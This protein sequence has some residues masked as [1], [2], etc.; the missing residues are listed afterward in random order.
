MMARARLLYVY[1]ERI[2]ADLRALVLS[3]LP[4]EEFEIQTMTY[5]LPPEEQAARLAWADVVLFAPGRYLPDEILAHARRVRLMQLWSSGYDKFNVD[6]ATRLGIPVANNGGAN[7][8]AVAEHTVLLMLA[9]SKWLPD[10]HRRVLTGQ[11]AG[12]SHGMD[13]RLLTGKRLGLVGFGAIGREVA[14]KV[15]GFE[16]EICYYDTRRADPEVE[17]SLRASLRPLEEVLR[18]S[19]VISL[20]VRHSMETRHLIGE[21]ELSLMARTP[22]LVNTARA[23][24]VDQDALLRALNVGRIAGAGLDVFV[25]EPT[26]AGDPLLA[27]LRVVAT[28]HMAGSTQETYVQALRNAVDNFRRVMAGEEPRWVVNG[29]ASR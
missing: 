14:R 8:T 28:P 19:D 24:L 2:P 10:S 26:V 5:A 12:N 25:K 1:E 16:M 4:P 21:R 6:G 18:E 20:H 3:Q 23:E 22:I 17:R 29:V 9:V 13:M 15:Q 27:H 7:A 11:W